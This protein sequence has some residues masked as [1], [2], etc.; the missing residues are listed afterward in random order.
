[1][2][3]GTKRWAQRDGVWVT[4]RAAYTIGNSPS[5]RG[6]CGFA[7]ATEARAIPLRVALGCQLTVNRAERSPPGPAP[8][9]VLMNDGVAYGA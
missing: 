6:C 7:A 8:R 9:V 1:M 3:Y 2:L 5:V 4:W